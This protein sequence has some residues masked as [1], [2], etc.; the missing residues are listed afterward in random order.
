MYVF[1][2]LTVIKLDILKAHYSWNLS[3]KFQNQTL[4]FEE[5][6]VCKF[7]LTLDKI[8]YRNLVSIINVHLQL[9]RKSKLHFNILYPTAIKLDNLKAHYSWNLCVK[10]QKH[11]SKTEEIKLC[12]SV[13]TFNKHNYKWLRHTS[14]GSLQC[15]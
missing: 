8:K 15:T 7:V 6:K 1:Q 13:F 3:V 5:I 2:H 11:T 12:K 9:L 10:F 4:Y 14:K